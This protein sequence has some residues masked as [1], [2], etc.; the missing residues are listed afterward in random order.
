VKSK[1][2][3][4]ELAIVHSAVPEQANEL[5]RR[6]GNLFPEDKILVL[7]LGSALGAHGGPGVL[8]LAL[9]ESD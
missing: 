2:N 1:E 3:I 8:L 4:Q 6:L 7:E 5:K 9:R